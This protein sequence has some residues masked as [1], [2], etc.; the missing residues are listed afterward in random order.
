MNHSVF[1]S[2]ARSA[3]SGEAERLHQAVG[4]GKGLAFL[5]TSGIAPGEGFPRVLAEA[6]LES[7]GWREAALIPI[8]LP[9]PPLSGLTARC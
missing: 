1:I 9:W 4:G 2:Y 5:D 8:Q 6:L 7:R 3:S